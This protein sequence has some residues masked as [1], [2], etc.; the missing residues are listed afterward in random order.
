MVDTRGRRRQ[1]IAEEN[2]Q[3]R[4]DA[5]KARFRKWLS[6]AQCG[7]DAAALLKARIEAQAES[8]GW[9]LPLSADE[10]KKILWQLF[11]DDEADQAGN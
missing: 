6:Q 7:K 9:A 5:K 1:E 2:R 4:V 11:T 8:I 3:I 10:R